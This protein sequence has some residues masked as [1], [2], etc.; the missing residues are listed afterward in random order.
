MKKVLAA[1]A[2][3]ITIS[4]MPSMALAADFRSAKQGPLDIGKD[5]AAKNLYAAASTINTSANIKGDLVAAGSSI[6]VQG[7]VED[8]LVAAGS[9]INVQGKIGQNAKLAGSNI[10]LTGN[11][12]GDLLAGGAMI[13]VSDSSTIGG[14]L[15]AGVT[16]LSLSGTVSGKARIA[17][18]D[19][20]LNGKI[21]GDTDIWATNVTLGDKAIINGKLTYH[22]PNTAAISESANVKGGIDYQKTENQKQYYSK[23]K[24]FGLFGTLGILGIL[25]TLALLFVVVYLLPKTSKNYVTE[26]LSSFWNNLGWGFLTLVAVPVGLI[27]VSIT[28]IGVKLA[29][30]LFL[31]YGALLAVAGIYGTIAI[32]AQL[33]RWFDSRLKEFRVDWLT[34]LIATLATIILALIPIAGGLIVFAFMLVGLGQLVQNI[35]RFLKSQR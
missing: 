16:T 6:N 31:L 8:S 15:I 35:T 34:I 28:I 11:I 10:N 20:T 22:S 33:L 3:L 17:G 24:M 29:A 26:M 30:I 14:D 21:D 25:A 23:A 2:L 32:G 1:I 19:V 9:N 12:G 5:E 7:D 27:I 4:M 18:T 13:S